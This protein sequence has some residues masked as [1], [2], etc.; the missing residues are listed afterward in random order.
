MLAMLPAIS[1][2]QN[3]TDYYK[4]IGPTVNGA[5]SPMVIENAG[6]NLTW[7]AL[8]GSGGNNSSIDARNASIDGFNPEGLIGGLTWPYNAVPGVLFIIIGFMLGIIMYIKLD[9]ELLIPGGILI[10]TGIL[11]GGSNLAF[12]VPWEMILFSTIAIVLGIG[13]IILQLLLGRGD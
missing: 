5:P 6:Y 8:F 1:M 7:R 10:I 11:S 4:W 2:A 9:G 3:V 13:A 12:A